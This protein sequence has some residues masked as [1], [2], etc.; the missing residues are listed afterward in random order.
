MCI[1]IVTYV[2]GCIFYRN[3]GVSCLKWRDN[4]TEI[5]RRYVKD[6]T[7]NLWQ[8]SFFGAIG[9][10]YFTVKHGINNVKLTASSLA[11]ERANLL[12]HFFPSIFLRNFC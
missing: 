6:C 12:F 3:F 7:H 1:F 10:V 8:N 4:N 2:F 9:V 5:C 11:T